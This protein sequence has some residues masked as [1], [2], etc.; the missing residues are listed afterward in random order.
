[1]TP[2]PPKPSSWP[3]SARPPGSK[4]CLSCD[5]RPSEAIIMA[6]QR[7]PA[8]EQGTP[9][10]TGELR[11]RLLRQRYGS[12]AD[13]LT[14]PA[15]TI[16]PPPSLFRLPQN[17]SAV[18]APLQTPPAPLAEM[19]DSMA[20]FAE[21]TLSSTPDEFSRR[22]IVLIQE[23]AV[24]FQHSKRLVKVPLSRGDPSVALREILRPRDAPLEMFAV[25]KKVALAQFVFRTDA[26]AVSARLC[27]GKDPDSAVWST[28]N[29]NSGLLMLSGLELPSLV[30]AVHCLLGTIGEARFSHV[31]SSRDLPPDLKDVLRR[32]FLLTFAGSPFLFIRYTDQMDPLRA[33]RAFQRRLLQE[34]RLTLF[35]VPATCPRDTGEDFDC[36]AFLWPHPQP[37]RWMCPHTLRHTVLVGVVTTI[38]DSLVEVR[39]DGGA[40]LGVITAEE[41][42]DTPGV[43]LRTLVAVRQRVRTRILG[44][45]STNGH[46]WYQC[47]FRDVML[48]PK[49]RL[50]LIR[51]VQRLAVRTNDSLRQFEIVAG[52]VVEMPADGSYLKL[53]IGH[54]RDFAYLPAA[55]NGLSLAEVQAYQVG[56]LINVRVHRLCPGRFPEIELSLQDLMF[57]LSEVA[58][59][60][61]P[62]PDPD[63]Q[64]GRTYRGLVARVANQTAEVYFG[65]QRMAIL[66]PPQGREMRVG[67]KITF[68]IETLSPLQAHG[69]FLALAEEPAARSDPVDLALQKSRLGFLKRRLQIE[70]SGDSAGGLHR[71]RTVTTSSTASSKPR[72]TPPAS[73]SAGSLGRGAIRVTGL[74]PSVTDAL[75]AQF[76]RRFARDKVVEVRLQGGVAHVRFSSVEDAQR[77]ATAANG[78]RLGT[79]E[80]SRIISVVLIDAGVFER[81]AGMAKPKAS[82]MARRLSS[83]AQPSQT[84]APFS[85]DRRPLGSTILDS[86][87]TDVPPQRLSPTAEPESSP[88]QVAHPTRA[89]AAVDVSSLRRASALARTEDGE[90]PANPAKKRRR[91]PEAPGSPMSNSN[92]SRGSKSPRMLSASSSSR[93][94]SSGRSGE[95]DGEGESGSSPNPH[96]VPL[97]SLTP[98]EQARPSPSV[99][100]HAADPGDDDLLG[101]E[102]PAPPFSPAPSTREGSITPDVS[103]QKFLDYGQLLESL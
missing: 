3:T 17:S 38:T 9:P 14:P 83:A 70:T 95:E 21:E 45:H 69:R 46:T 4:H 40:A 56:C 41:A 93:T 65:T 32:D 96:E 102:P 24:D 101:L 60:I 61:T 7:P 63:V 94:S 37:K 48:L 23:Q 15:G 11:N 42:S 47:S 13:P 27:P 28:A 54:V 19:L 43:D 55:A 62:L 35:I 34:F 8:R 6:D 86:Y 10:T 26:Q 18:P 49:E 67:E 91:T 36:T 39:L 81:P 5:P 66:P 52:I 80:D 72:P 73:T 99:G 98:P 12:G 76:F 51:A 103:H 88:S 22:E 25:Q 89:P 92:G 79:D 29:S 44:T 85:S 16:Q 78:S 68:R 97:T 59:S 1:V 2:D 64:V 75:V 30:P 84:L 53:D 87:A 57:P 100:E 50:D 58:N 33:L 90:A 77:A 71:E 82:P 20:R 31:L 74:A